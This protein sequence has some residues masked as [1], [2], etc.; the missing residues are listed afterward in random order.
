MKIT[1]VHPSWRD[2]VIEHLADDAGARERFLGSCSINGALLAL[3]IA[4][5]SRGDRIMPLLRT[6]GDWD[7]LTDRLHDLLPELEPTEL[8]GMFDAL[9]ATIDSLTPGHLRVETEALAGAVLDRVAALWNRSRAPIG[10]SQLEAWLTLASLLERPPVAPKLATTWAELLPVGAPPLA[11]I[12]ALE[13]FADW[14]GLLELLLD[15]QQRR[16]PELGFPGRAMPICGAFL[17]SVDSGIDGLDPR[18][19]APVARALAR[20]GRVTAALSEQARLLRRRLRDDD[21]P[22][23]EPPRPLDPDPDPRVGA[24][25]IER[26]LR[27]L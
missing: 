3:S 2:L 18:A 27:D 24:L 16:L 5:G 17:A 12:A 23:P 13:R 15:H 8:I 19:I 4:G 9:G 22:A 7:R 21:P 1:W 14:L 10:L 6:D 26:V 25:D 11:D 20:I